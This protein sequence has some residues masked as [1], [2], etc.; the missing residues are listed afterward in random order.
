MS[1]TQYLDFIGSVWSLLPEEDKVRLGELWQ[2]FEQCVASAYQKFV[3]GNLNITHQNLQAFS[4][5]RWLDYTFDEANFLDQPAIYTS[6]Q[7]ISLGINLNLRYLLKIGVDGGEPIEIDVRG[8]N[9]GSTK[10]SEIVS[11]INDAFHFRFARAVL[12]NS[13]LQLVS[14]TTG[15]NSK[16]TIYDTS[17]PSA[18]AAEFI[19]GI[20]NSDLPATFPEYPY[21]Y[22]SPYPSLASIPEF[23]NAVRDETVTMLLK[24]GQDYIVLDKTT[25]AFK[26]Q[27][28]AILW[29]RRSFF[30]QE[31]PWNNYGFLMDIY[32]KNSVR[33]VNVIQG[34]W[35]AFW[36]GPKPRNVLRSLYLLFGLPTAKEDGTV[37]AVSSTVVETTSAAGV[38]RTFAVP[39][40]LNPI[41]TLGQS[42]ARFDPLVDGIE[43]FDKVNKP[44]FIAEQIGR[45]GIQRFL[46][47]GASRG[48][49][50]T[51]E[52]KAL[53][54]LE[55]YTFLP[56]ISVDAF[57]N[58]DINLGNVKIFLDAIKPLNKTYLFQI[59]AGNFNDAISFSEVVG[60][61]PS[62]DLTETVDSN[63]TTYLQQADLDD[64]E[65][66]A[67]SGLNLDPNGVL[68][69]D[70]I[71]VDVYSG[72]V[73][74]DSFS[75]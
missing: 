61:S 8:V 36:T 14:R 28:P 73:L 34:L 1:S 63:E 43:V 35:F 42:V 74:I 7:D 23:Q 51:D 69:E 13:V 29:A 50:D 64:Y 37:T 56:Q 62:I 5:E 12:S 6:T 10:L 45:S 2:G 15:I 22:Q 38:V 75:A 57:V 17:V 55:E 68:F 48:P 71:E 60:A 9:P 16:I 65:F 54:L 3:E 4:S 25:V 11:K 66:N 32:Q 19:L 18:N 31:N 70:T 41:V 30:D 27:P 47:P 40:G 21:V 53:T 52:T 44:G 33:Y 26:T 24:E 67:N 39:F 49:G 46:T 59:I 58:P 72:A 20:Q